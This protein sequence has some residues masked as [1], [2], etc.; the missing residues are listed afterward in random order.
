[1]SIT[2]AAQRVQ[3]SASPARTPSTRTTPG[4]SPRPAGYSPAAFSCRVNADQ[5]RTPQAVAGDVRAAFGGIPMDVGERTVSIPLTGRAPDVEARGW[6]LAHY[7]VGNAAR[8]KISSV[9]STAT[10][11]PPRTRPTAGS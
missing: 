8:L 7:S 6:G 10:G 4:P 9:P 3:Q 1:M 11:G 2:E 5:R